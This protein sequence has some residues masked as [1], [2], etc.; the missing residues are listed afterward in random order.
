MRVNFSKSGDFLHT[1][2]HNNHSHIFV[3]Q[4]LDF[5]TKTNV[6]SLQ[7]LLEPINVF[8]L[9]RTSSLVHNGHA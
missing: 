9:G 1:H 4:F 6:P 2:T 5:A 8:P 3:I 7:H